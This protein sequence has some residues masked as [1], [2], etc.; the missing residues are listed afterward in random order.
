VL[1]PQLAQMLLAHAAGHD[2]PT[3]MPAG[4]AALFWLRQNMPRTA[5]K[6]LR[7]LRGEASPAG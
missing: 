5:E 7:E 4:Q 2:R 1:D 6:V 3:R